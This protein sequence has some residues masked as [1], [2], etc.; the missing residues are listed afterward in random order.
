MNKP[1]YL[2]FS[3]LGI[4]KTNMY[5]FW[6]GYIKPK[7]G[8]RAKLCYTDTDSFVIYIK[9][10]DFYED[11]TNDVERWF[12]TFNYDKNDE[13]LLPIGKKLGGNIITEFFA[14]RAKAYAYLKEDGREHKKAK[15]TKKCVIKHELTFKNY[16]YS[17][18]NDEIIL[19]TQE[20]FKNDH[21]KVYIEEINKIALSS[22]AD[23]ILQ[24][25]DKITTYPY[26]TN[27]FKVCE[28]EM[29]MS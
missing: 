24:T 1:I 17:L 5:E 25:F 19:K 21:H 11:I 4:S 8:D 26:V 16:K 22:N 18:F 28:S 14:L 15:R 3:I 2:G 9:T 27:A 13:R 20:R 12:D 10:E 29:L 7:Y 6:Y 23:K